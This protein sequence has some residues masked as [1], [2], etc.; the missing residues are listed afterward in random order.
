M[1]GSLQPIASLAAVLFVAGVLG[2][3][4]TP[5]VDTSRTEVKV[6]GVV[7]VKGKPA[8][9]GQISF[10][11]SNRDRKVAAFN[12]P[13]RPDGS[14]TIKTYTGENEVRFTG[15]VDKANPMVGMVKKFCIVSGDGQQQDFDLLA[16][17]QSEVESPKTKMMVKGAG[18]SGTG[19]RTGGGR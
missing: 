9:G 13:I 11:P 15:D 17:D 6:N 3:S 7:K 19:G 1:K 10:N 12:A 8:A 18:K 16:D 2:C 14:Y 4:D 5:S